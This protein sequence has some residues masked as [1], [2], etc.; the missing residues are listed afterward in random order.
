MKVYFGQIY[1]EPG[2]AFGFTHLFQAY[3]S[4]EI[5]ALVEPSVE[6][7][8]K[9]GRD[10][11]LM[12]N[13]SAKAAI[14]DNEIRGPAVFKKTKDVEFSVFLPFN[15]IVRTPQISQ[16]ALAFL[17]RGVYSVFELLHID[18]S[19]IVEKQQSLITYICSDPTMFEGKGNGG[20]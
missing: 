17:F 9:Y 15:V 10:Y 5:T 12:F 18:A 14:Q 16:S 3:L 1:I 19:R 20:T 7:I 13:I 2:V 8:N 11:N 4:R 6:F